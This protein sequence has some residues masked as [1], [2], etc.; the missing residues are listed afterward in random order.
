MHSCMLCMLHACMHTF[1]VDS[2]ASVQHISHSGIA[3]LID[4]VPLHFPLNFRN[5]EMGCTCASSFQQVDP[6]AAY[7]NEKIRFTQDTYKYQLKEDYSVAVDIKDHNVDTTFLALDPTG[8]LLIRKGYV[9]DGPSGPTYDTPSFM[10]AAL[11]HDSLYELMRN[12]HLDNEKYRIVADQTMRKIAKQDGMNCF[13]RFYTYYG[14]F[15]EVK[16]IN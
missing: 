13:R 11:V 5:I 7:N 14:K 10:R 8:L 3:S 9:W 4:L 2:I 12:G 6:E 16:F 15:L 1:Y